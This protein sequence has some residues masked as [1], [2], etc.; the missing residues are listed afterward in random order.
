MNAL[1][2]SFFVSRTVLIHM[3]PIFVPVI[4][5][6]HSLIMGSAVQVR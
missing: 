6:T 1:K 3:A 2:E 4:L 5:A